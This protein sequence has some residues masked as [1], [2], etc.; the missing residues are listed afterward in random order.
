MLGGDL[1]APLLVLGWGSPH[2]LQLLDG[3]VQ[4]L[5]P[6]ESLGFRFRHAAV[7]FSVVTG[8]LPGGIQRIEEEIV[9]SGGETA[10]GAH[11]LTI[12][13]PM[14]RRNSTNG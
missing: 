7:E 5:D 1:S 2:W 11:V 8:G 13:R 10:G 4:T 6:G 14:I 3:V 9:L 12:V